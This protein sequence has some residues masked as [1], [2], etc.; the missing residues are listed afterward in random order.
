MMKEKDCWIGKKHKEKNKN[1]E[2]TETKDK[3]QHRCRAIL[4]LHGAEG[5][6]GALLRTTVA[7]TRGDIDR[8]MMHMVHR[9]VAHG[10]VLHDALIHL[11]ESQTAAIHEGAVAQRDVLVS[12]I[13]FRTQLEAAAYPAHRLRN[14]TAIE[15]RTQLVARNHTVDDGNMLGNHWLLQGVG[16]LQHQGII[17]RRIDL[18]VGYG[19]ILAAV[20]VEA[21]TI[22]IDGY[23]IHGAQFATR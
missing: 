14:V 20:D 7:A 15:Q 3:D 12:A 17:A 18:A 4:R 23:I 11:L 5:Y 10:D 2:K 22:G 8:I 1:K 19:E 21:I 13:R 6:R 9:D 16:T